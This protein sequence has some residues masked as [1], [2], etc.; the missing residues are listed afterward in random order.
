MK[1]TQNLI[2][3][4]HL[5]RKQKY[6]KSWSMHENF[7]IDDKYLDEILQIINR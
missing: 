3:N 1:Q 5:K 2:I 7:E 4:V 6:C